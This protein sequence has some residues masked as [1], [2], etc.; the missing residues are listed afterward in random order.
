M[1]LR[2]VRRGAARAIYT[3]G[4]PAVQ[5]DLDKALR[6]ARQT[7]PNA[8]DAVL[9]AVRLVA[10]G[11]DPRDVADECTPLGKA[12]HWRF[13]AYRVSWFWGTRGE[14]IIVEFWRKKG[15]KERRERVES[16]NKVF[17]RYHDEENDYS[18]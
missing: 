2:L 5:T 18:D 3:P 10:D 15:N 12:L 13:G 7:A 4:R 1:R 8:V 6:E 17:R 9:A 14:L 11:S 16:L